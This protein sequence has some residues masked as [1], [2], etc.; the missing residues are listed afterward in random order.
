MKNIIKK[1]LNFRIAPTYKVTYAPE[2]S[3]KSELP[4][5]VYN[6]VGNPKNLAW[7]SHAGHKLFTAYTADKQKHFIAFRADRVLSINFS[8]LTLVAKTA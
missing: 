5:Q 4:I 7:R 2:T 6:I 3:K 1:I 8:G